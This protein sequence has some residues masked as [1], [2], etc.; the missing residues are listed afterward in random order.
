MSDELKLNKIISELGPV[1]QSNIYKYLMKQTINIQDENYAYIFHTPN[2][3]LKYRANTF[4]SKEPETI[5][6]INEYVDGVFWDIGANIGLYSIYAAKN[7]KNITVYSFE[8]SA[9]NL[10]SLAKNVILNK[11]SENINILPIA[12][13]NKS[14]FQKLNLQNLE[15]GN[16][17]N[18]FGVNYDYNG[19]EFNADSS[20]LTYGTSIAQLINKFNL[21]MPNHI[22]IDVDGIEHQILE[23][24]EDIL[25]NDNV[26]TIQVEINEE[27]VRQKE[28]ILRFMDNHNF[29]MV[30]KKQGPEFVGSQYQ[31]NF[32]Y[33]FKK[34]N[35]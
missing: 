3:L 26:K 21:P 27:F 15:E 11:C 29:K 24:G 12:L 7:K 10:Y 16:A 32:N 17:L 25:D 9:T 20:Y 34:I 19:K 33:L 18:A 4:F 23:G 28:E 14:G 5:E 31:M 6:W 30:H 1:N 13:T 22:K 35:C 2:E 8:P